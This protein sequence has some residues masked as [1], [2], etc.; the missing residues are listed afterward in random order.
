MLAMD[1]AARNEAAGLRAGW[2]LAQFTPL[3]VMP[4]TVGTAIVIGIGGPSGSV[5][6]RGLAVFGCCP[7]RGKGGC[8][9]SRAA[10]AARAF[11]IRFSPM[12]KR[13]DIRRRA[14]M[15]LF[16]VFFV[17]MFIGMGVLSIVLWL[18]E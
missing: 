1:L 8:R 15:A 3:V 5:T 4:S 7:V 9:R 12:P 14:T 17:G 2:L 18:C 16:V 10:S 13:G 6:P 11:G